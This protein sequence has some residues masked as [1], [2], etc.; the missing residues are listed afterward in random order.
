MYLCIS[1]LVLII[2]AYLFNKYGASLRLTEFNF[3][4]YIFYYEIIAESFIASLLVVYKLDNHYMISRVSDSSRIFGW[5]AVQWT[6]I[7]MGLGLI[8]GRYF[9]HETNSNKT[10]R[11]YTQKPIFEFE[12]KYET[13]I[14]II[15]IALSIISLL[16][17][18]YYCAT[19]G[20]I[21]LFRLIHDPSLMFSTLRSDINRNYGGI[22]YIKNVFSISLSPILAYI[23]YAMK[24]RNNTFYNRVW[25]FVMMCNAIIALTN[26][27]AKAPVAWFLLKYLFLYVLINSKIKR[28]YLYLAG[29]S[30]LG[31]LVAVYVFLLKVPFET[32]F[33]FNSGIMGRILLSQSAGT[34]FSFEYFPSV[35][36]HLGFSSFPTWL[37]SL[38]GLE[39][40]ERSARICMEIFNPRGVEAGVAGVINSLFIAESWANWGFIGV[41]IAPIIAGFFIHVLFFSLIKLPKHPIVIG[42]ITYFCTMVPITGGINDFIYPISFI[43]MITILYLCFYMSNLIIRAVKENW[44]AHNLSST[45]TTR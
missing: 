16:A 18:M 3:C 10:F 1:I 2:S 43:I 15:L 9:T 14:R 42:F 29:A 11:I 37:T 30:V 32:L 8:V 19:I 38:F 28:K 33:H 41:L 12:Y 40:S 4:T 13:C 39:H 36:E 23:W 27:L 17:T 26:N 35:H 34:Y 21:T 25:A 24:K 6:M 31:L 5:A 44:N 7:G 20:G 45:I 22:E